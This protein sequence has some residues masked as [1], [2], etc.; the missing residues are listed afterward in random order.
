MPD[1]GAASLAIG[2]G[3]A[4]FAVFLP[5]LTDVRKYNPKDNPDFAADVRVGEIAAV[6]VTMGIGLISSAL[7]GSQAP[8]IVSLLVCAILVTLYESVLRTDRMLEPKATILDYGILE[9]DNA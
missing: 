1:F 5:K 8:A 3:V 9:G 7:T 6:S 2:Q 4:S